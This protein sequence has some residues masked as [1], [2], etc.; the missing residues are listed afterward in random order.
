M[1][2]NIHFDISERKVL[3]RILDVASVLTL[4]YLVGVIFDFEYF[5]INSEHWVWSIVLSVYLTV[6]ATIFELYNL[7]KASKFEVVV[8][9]V[10]ITSSITVLFYLLTPFYTPSLPTNRL[11]IVYFFLAINVALLLWRYAYISFVSAPRFYKRTLLVAHGEHVDTIVGSLQKSDPNYKVVGYFDTS[12]NDSIVISDQEIVKLNLDDFALMAEDTTISEIVVCTPL[13]EGITLELNNKLIKLLE[14]GVSIREYIQ[15]YEELTHRIPVQ[16]VERDFY[17]YFPFSRNNQ[18]KLYLFFNRIL[19]LVL[20][21]LGLAS[22]LL[23][24]PIVLIGNL[25]GNRGSL[26]YTQI[27]VGRNGEHFKIYKLRSMV[28]NAE[29]NGAQFAQE[30]DVRVTKFGRFLRKTRFDEIPQFL[31]VLKGDMSV[32]GPRPERPEFVESLAEKLPFYEVRHVVKPGITG[33]AQ[34][35]AKYGSSEEDSL[36]KLQYDL[37]YIKHRSLFLDVVVIIKTLS[38]IVFFRGQ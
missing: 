5:I 4:L 34:V 7:Q 8:K 6:F 23:L 2:N 30:R 25:L 22:G 38:T 29:E 21:G 31:N 13:S 1:P 20:G 33:W 18:N 26:L 19:D 11:Q 37:Y 15:V 24:L 27:R 17:R 9:N 32:I 12:S 35:N 14:R 28:K 36:E 16:H 10:I 3:L